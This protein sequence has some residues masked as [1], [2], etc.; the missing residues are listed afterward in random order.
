MNR[1][2]RP[3]RQGTPR[4]CGSS[5]DRATRRS[6]PR[7]S[8]PAGAGVRSA[9]SR[10]CRADGY[11]RP[12][13]RGRQRGRRPGCHVAVEHRNDPGRAVGR[14]HG[15][16]RHVELL[17]VARVRRGRTR[18]GLGAGRARVH[19]DRRPRGRGVA[20]DGRHSPGTSS[21][22]ARSGHRVAPGPPPCRSAPSTRRPRSRD[23][24]AWPA[25]AVRRRPSWASG[26]VV[27]AR[28]LSAA[29]TWSS[30]EYL[31]DVRGGAPAD[32]GRAR[33]GGE[34]GGGVEGVHRL[35]A[36]CKGIGL[37]GGAPVLAD[38]V[39]PGHRLRWP[40]GRVLGHAA[41]LVDGHDRLGLRGR[42]DGQRLLGGPRL[43]ER[44]LVP[45]HG[46]RHRRA[47]QRDRRARRRARWSRSHVRTT[48]TPTPT[49]TPP[50]PTGNTDA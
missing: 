22:R 43:R 12:A 44:R 5:R 16:Q 18:C 25:A 10:P 31:S 28:T 30:V 37:D 39:R 6:S 33:R 48:P 32:P 20:A 42:H 29:G 8:A 7:G 19:R 40:G 26:G 9:T 11:A 41:G 38:L 14:R 50:T 3:T 15:G 47:R 24:S 36:R 34:R 17:P 49:P 1:T 21:P 35:L 4:P 23:R 2:W 13:R 46:H 27:Q 45:G